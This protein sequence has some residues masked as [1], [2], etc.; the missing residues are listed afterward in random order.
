[1]ANHPPASRAA[2]AAGGSYQPLVIALA[3]VC[4]GVMADR[5]MPQ[6]APAWWL[7]ALACWSGW[8]VLHAC[9]LER[10]SSIC[11][12]LCLAGVGAA[13]HHG[14]WNLYPRDELASLAQGDP[15]PVA[16]EARALAAPRRIPAPPPSPLRAMEVPDRSRLA[17]W[18]TSVRSGSR[19]RPASGEA[20]LLVDGHLLGVHAGDRLRV[21]G[22]LSVAQPAENPGDLDFGEYAR[23]ERRLSLLRA[24]F[25]DAVTVLEPGSRWTLRRG[26]DALR[27][28]GDALL[29]R[30]LDEQQSGLAA[31][32]LLN[33]REQLP[34]DR[35]SA[36]V[37]TS[38]IHILAISGMHVA[39]LAS[40]LFYGLRFGLLPRRPALLAVA[41]ATVVYTVL[42]DAPPSAVRAMIVVLLVCGALYL[43][44]PAAAFNCW[45]AGGLVVLALNPADLFRAGPQLS[46]LAVGTMAWMGPLWAHWQSQDPLDRL[47]ARSRG[48]PIRTLAWLGR[49][50]ARATLVTLA[51]WLVA[52]PL[53]MARFHLFSPVGI[54]MTTLLCVPVTLALMFGFALLLLGWLL[55]PAGAACGW[56]CDLS[57]A[58]VD[59]C[60]LAVDRLPGSHQWVT[61]PDPWWVAG[62]YAGLAV[63]AAWPKLRRRRLLCTGVLIGWI[64]IGCGEAWAD[65]RGDAA[66][67][68]TFLSVGHGAAVV[69]QL[70][71]GGTVLY[72][73]GSLGSPA[74]ATQSIAGYLWS[75]G[76][77]RLEAVVVSHAD[78]DHFNALPEL[79][80]KFHVERVYVSPVMRLSEAEAVQL[81]I[82]AVEAS[83]A[84]LCEVSSG[85]WIP[86][87]SACQLS[88][89]HPPRQGVAGSDNANSIVLAVEYLGRRILLTGDLE[90][91]GMEQLT[92][93]SGYDCDV[94]LAPHHG[95]PRSDPPGFAAWSRPEWVVI[96]GGH[97]RD[98]GP[99]QFA[100][101]SQGAC[102]LH[103]AYDGAVQASIDRRGVV[104]RSWNRG[105]WRKAAALNGARGP[106]AGSK[107][108]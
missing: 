82:D 72:D 74:V 43:G 64:G 96:S 83:G 80:E 67:R 15:K 50:T 58:L 44:R 102:V 104:V 30:Y 78:V 21:F 36:F 17:V 65:R 28:G 62:F 22:Q 100:Y 68:C 99:V 19:W 40:C 75:E 71:E 14:W 69:L 77:W 106:E 79:L 76:I 108:R 49:W 24:E 6:P 97:G 7:M 23:A 60:V 8:A 81:L 90:S 70:P 2:S 52:L 29:W 1:M 25:P 94:L 33:A 5:Y 89:L 27:S 20:L 93:Q 53:V 86:A 4:G 26:L 3:V 16:V 35:I 11:L 56:V 85:E 84:E 37:R 55:P 88:V 42:T 66:L 95:S 59:G 39:I 73:A 87:D 57:L 107:R 47:I 31:A 63:W 38:T 54:V 98:H 18:I 91:P 13:W 41:V 12:S 10:V 103:T 9:R 45:G 34:Y 92:S 61:G 46:F 105:E 51:I 32:L 48:L 101:G